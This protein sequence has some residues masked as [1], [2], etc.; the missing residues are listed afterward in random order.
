MFLE[1]EDSR[2]DH[3]LGSLVEFRFKAPSGTTSFS[4]TTHTP[5]GQRNRASWASKLR[6]RLHSCH[7]QEGG[8]RSPQRT[9]GDNGPK[10]IKL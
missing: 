10:K 8:P 2:G 6:S 9:C 7:A 1:R 4:I 5:S 3:G